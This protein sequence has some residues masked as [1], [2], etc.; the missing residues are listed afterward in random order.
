MYVRPPIDDPKMLERLPVPYRN[1]LARANGYVAYDGG[2]HV[3][4]ACINPE[5]HSLRA[6]W[7]GSRALHRLFPGLTPQDIPFA[8]DALGDQYVLRTDVVHRL[9]GETGE[10]ESLGV[11]LVGFDAAVRADP[12]AYLNLAPLEEFRAEGGS[13]APGQ[14]LS[15]Y[16]PYVFDNSAASVSFRAIPAADRI[17][18]L[19]SLAAQL[20]G[21]PDGTA[22]RLTIDPPAS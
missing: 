14:L 12:I 13:L 9:A 18:F 10:V 16:P 19:A 3:R 7:D 22:V 6:A 21:I 11:D 17:G 2:L 15:V 1:L 4:G 20:R 5:W 8:E